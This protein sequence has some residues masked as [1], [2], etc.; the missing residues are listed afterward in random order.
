[1]SRPSVNV[2]SNDLILQGNKLGLKFL[3]EDDQS[4][5]KKE[6]YS[7]RNV[8]FMLDIWQKSEGVN[9]DDCLKSEEKFQLE[10]KLHAYERS[11]QLANE[12]AMLLS[13]NSLYVQAKHTN[14]G[15]YANP[16]EVDKIKIKKPKDCAIDGN[17]LQLTSLNE[18]LKS[19]TEREVGV[20]SFA[21]NPIHEESRATNDKS[22]G[23]S[24]RS[25]YTPQNGSYLSKSTIRVLKKLSLEENEETV[26][27][28]PVDNPNEIVKITLTGP[29]E[30]NM[31]P[32]F[33]SDGNRSFV[34]IRVKRRL[35]QTTYSPG[36]WSKL[37]QSS[38]LPN[39]EIRISETFDNEME[40]EANQFQL[41]LHNINALD[42]E[43]GTYLEG[44]KFKGESIM[45]DDDDIDSILSEHPEESQ[46][47]PQQEEAV[48]HTPIQRRLSKFQ[49]KLSIFNQK[50][51]FETVKA[52]MRKQKR[53]YTH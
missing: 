51:Y 21:Q 7:T 35:L 36:A 25:I 20:K 10:K 15:I 44:R 1:M 41:V 14:S 26:P 27:S 38:F 13:N 30:V 45:E 8:E 24:P 48:Y 49:R 31:Q 17:F 2:E 9:L 16:E 6:T 28:L 47:L 40:P 3:K 53:K 37:I 43:G 52:R 4:V 11:K 46:I 23:L 50:V 34:P 32:Y 39:G 5:L 42:E 22:D 33:L 18:E 29:Q 12:R 19:I